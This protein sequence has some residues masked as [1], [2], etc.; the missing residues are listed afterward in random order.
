[1]TD[2]KHDTDFSNTK[3]PKLGLAMALVP[4]GAGVGVAIDN[5]PLGAGAGGIL[6][7]VFG[8]MA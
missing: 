5:L 3:G 2:G 8:A 4:L 6:A 7:F 1:M